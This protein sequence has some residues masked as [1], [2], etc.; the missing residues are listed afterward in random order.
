MHKK[1]DYWMLIC[2]CNS[3]CLDLPFCLN[4]TLLA[5]TDI[6]LRMFSSVLESDPTELERITSMTYEAINNWTPIIITQSQTTHC[7]LR[8]QRSQ[9]PT[10]SDAIFAWLFCT[11]ISGPSW[12]DFSVLKGPGLPGLQQRAHH[13][14]SWKNVNRFW[15]L[16]LGLESMHFLLEAQ[17]SK[18][19]NA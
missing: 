10:D 14:E 9:L 5:M 17:K 1:L 19:K 4:M 11:R 15:V 6:F 16:V 8:L 13:D 7:P 18:F 2:G 12:L 3:T